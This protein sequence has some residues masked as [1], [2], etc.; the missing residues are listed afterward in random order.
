LQVTDALPRE[1]A[2]RQSALKKLEQARLQPQK[3]R[4]D[5]V[6][7]RRRRR[8]LQTP[9]SINL[10]LIFLRSFC[11]SPSSCNI[12]T[13]TTTTATNHGPFSP[14]QEDLKQVCQRLEN[15]CNTMREKV[16][17][18]LASRGEERLLVFR[19]VGGGGSGGDCS[20]TTVVIGVLVSYQT[21]LASPQPTPTTHILL[22]H[23]SLASTNRAAKEDEYEKL[24][25]EKTQLSRE[26]E[27]KVRRR[28]RRRDYCESEL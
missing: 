23:A 14:H 13:T 25:M 28:R 7:R 24:S 2:E 15:D 27:E 17:K 1:L 22:Q 26:I 16:E 9:K 3:T 6:R 20:S 8:N 5:V 4:E 19:Q 21:V 10:P 11:A 12:T 18:T